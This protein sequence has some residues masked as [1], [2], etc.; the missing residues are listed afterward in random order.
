LLDGLF[1]AM[2]LLTFLPGVDGNQKVSLRYWISVEALAIIGWV[3][4]LIIIFW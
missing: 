3:I 1:L 4:M 2:M